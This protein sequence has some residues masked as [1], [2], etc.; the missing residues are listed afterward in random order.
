[1][2]I[3]V[4]LGGTKIEVVALSEAG[5]EMIRRRVDTPEE[6]SLCLAAIAALVSG[7]EADVGEIGSVG[8]ATPGAESRVTGLMKN[9][10]LQFL[11]GQHLRADLSKVLDR[12]VLIA[13]DADCLVLSEA[14]DGAAAGCDPVFGAILGTGVGGG[15][16]VGGRLVTGPNGIAGEWG[17]N[18]L[19]YP[20]IDY[21]GPLPSCYCRSEE[22][23]SELQSH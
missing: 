15:V 4:D 10:N 5:E 12:E 3:G 9:S 19:P 18:P 14:T 22:H 7:V 16:V 11:N 13:N 1:M 17:H 23:T 20:E 21:P 6:Y 8:A 2:R